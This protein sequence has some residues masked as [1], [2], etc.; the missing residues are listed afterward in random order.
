M[1]S[2]VFVSHFVD[3]GGGSNVTVARMFCAGLV[4]PSLF[5][6]FSFGA[7]KTKRYKCQAVI[8]GLSTPGM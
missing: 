2:V 6:E 7:H 5:C 8:M 4:Q 3:R 1:F